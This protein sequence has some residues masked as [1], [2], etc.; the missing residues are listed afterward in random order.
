MT[1]RAQHTDD[2]GA[3][4]IVA[5]IFITVVSVVVAVVL[6]LT[7]SSIRTTLALRGQA[8]DAASVDGAA[9]IAINAL[10]QGI[11]DASAGA[12][13]D[14]G[15]GVTSDTLTLTNFY[16]PAS[17]PAYSAAV[18]CEPDPTTGGVGVDINASNKPGSAILTLGTSATET[19]LHINAS[20]GREVKVHGGVF[21][22]SSIT[23]A[24]GSL[25]SDASLT[26]RG[27]CT[28]TI[29]SV[30]A[31]NC[32][33]GSVVD[34][35]GDDPDYPAPTAA[36]TLR[37]V[38][39]C[40]TADQLV[41]FTPGL[42]TN[43][44]ALNNLTRCTNGIFHFLPGTYYFNLPSGT[45][46]LIEQAYVV[47]G[48]PTTPLVAGTP[49]TIPGSCQSPT[50]PDPLPPGWTP[51]AP[52]AGVQF[53]LGG[54][55]QIV[56]RSAQ[57]ELCGSYS[58]AGPPIAI[59]GL[60]TA[61]GPVPA[62]SGCTLVEPYPVSGCAA[63][64]SEDTAG[65]AFHI[66]GTTY[67]PRSVLDLAL[68]N[69]VGLAFSVGV[70]ARSLRVTPTATA[71][72]PD[73]VI[74]VPERL[75]S[76]PAH[77]GLSQRLRLSGL[78]HLQRRDGRQPPAGQGGHPGSDRRARSRGQGDHGLQLERA[79]VELRDLVGGEDTHEGAGDQEGPERD[80]RLAGAPATRDQ[81]HT[82]EGAEQERGECA[83]DEGCPGQIRQQRAEDAGELD[84]AEPHAARIGQRH[85]EQAAE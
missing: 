10:R 34:P 22:N 83:D 40:A 19:G 72:L 42:Y 24:Q 38:P 51:P 65:S 48:T 46:W 6:S 23:V 39:V 66:Q 80:R 56:L 12:C 28:G 29:S 47:G 84:I 41:T 15:G 45:P 50:P 14:A 33:I 21:A 2:S 37:V 70:I 8:S 27:A 67:L 62:Q 75:A 59:Y 54:G 5:L 1:P 78:G 63:I 4:L 74:E 61:V 43:I 71:A 82:H 64:R 79:A 25:R 58:A 16:Q 20:G 44:F 73:P 49:P 77:G 7:D 81:G 55:T 26:A 9:Q 17:G 60:K 31:P 32:G 36:T 18:T 30:P 3:T 35:R 57:V 85:R 53:V 69:S 68:N 13:F 11:Y 52:N 76:R